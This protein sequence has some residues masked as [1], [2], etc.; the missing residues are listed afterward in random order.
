MTA[1]ITVESIKLQLIK[2]QE[3]LSGTQDQEFVFTTEAIRNM[4]KA[5]EFADNTLS[6][7]I[8]NFLTKSGQDAVSEVVKGLNSTNL[9]VKST[10][11]MVLIRMGA[12]EA[13]R[14]F[15]L[16]NSHRKNLHWVVEFILNELGEPM[17]KTA[18]SNLEWDDNVV[19]LSK[20]G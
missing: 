7:E 13:V 3:F 17:P 8:E 2:N 1:A 12:V 14:E 11:A 20:V 15:F 19:A 16:A 4:V 18:A 5:L 10:C 6:S 9:N